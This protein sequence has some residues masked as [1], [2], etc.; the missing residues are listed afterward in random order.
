MF[1]SW[2]S[3][4]TRARQR[5][6]AATRWQASGSA[7]AILRSASQPPWPS[8]AG[9]GGHIGCGARG[10]VRPA[11]RGGG[12]R[13]SALLRPVSKGAGGPGDQP[14][15]ELG[16][17]RVAHNPVSD[18]Q[19]AIATRNG[20]QLK[21]TETP[22][23]GTITRDIVVIGGSAGS[24]RPMKQVMA[25]LPADL[26]ATLFIVMHVSRNS[27]GMLAE[28]LAS[29]GV[30]PAT[31]AEDGELFEHRHV[32]VAP[33]DR[34]L[35]VHSD[36]VRVMHGPHENRHRPA[37]DPLFRSAAATYGARVASVLLSGGP[38][39][40]MAGLWSIATCGGATIVQDPDDAE[41]KA[42]PKHA[43]LSFAVD[44]RLPAQEIG[45]LLVRLAREPIAGS[46]RAGC[47]VPE[48]NGQSFPHG[49]EILNGLGRVTPFTCPSCSGALWE[50]ADGVLRY[51]CH[52]GHAFSEASLLDAQAEKMEDTLYQAL[53]AIEERALST[54]RI[55]ESYRDTSGNLAAMFLKKSE[56]LERTAASLRRL[57]A[58]H[59]AE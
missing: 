6:R 51:R 47:Q 37:I 53:V 11:R 3:I 50:L 57:L 24:L 7:D 27:P 8:S 31:M 13:A 25:S 43:L 44:H 52:T 34:H 12:G 16:F 33:P 56:E 40:G 36:R 1:R 30:L 45:P 41:M 5:A 22:A 59:A 49:I 39:D 23:P 55:S 14:D 28:I 32:Y 21:S 42:M 54:R 46:V 20:S 17:A 15:R 2:I 58:G 9:S 38:G 10:S 4:T 48:E 19:A 29:A 26:P 18:E 35:L